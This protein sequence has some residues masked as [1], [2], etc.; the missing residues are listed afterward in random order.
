[1]PASFPSQTLVRKTEEGASAEADERLQ[2]QLRLKAQKAAEASKLQALHLAGERLTATKRRQL[3]ERDELQDLTHEYGML[4]KLKKWVGVGATQGRG[5]GEHGEGP[6][7]QRAA[8]NHRPS[9]LQSH[10]AACGR[11]GRLPATSLP[12]APPNVG[13]AA[14]S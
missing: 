10:A 8:N 12:P 11:R 3:Q 4:K 14:P 1:M 13:P 7:V 2:R 5:G 9:V 6:A